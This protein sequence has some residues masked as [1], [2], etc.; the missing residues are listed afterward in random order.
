MTMRLVSPAPLRV[1]LGSANQLL[2]P[3]APRKLRSFAERKTTMEHLLIRRSLATRPNIG[4]SPTPEKR[5]RIRISNFQSP[6]IVL[7]LLAG[8][9]AASASENWPC[10]RGPTGQGVS[11]EKDLPLTWSV[12]ENV[13]WR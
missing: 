13:A 1:V 9:L 5:N 8:Q 10:F 7:M 3:F 11:A 4:R 12:K 2:S 6:M